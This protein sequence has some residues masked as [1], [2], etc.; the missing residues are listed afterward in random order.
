MYSSLRVGLLL[1]PV[2][3]DAGEVGDPGVAGHY[4][5]LLR[6]DA[7]P[8]SGAADATYLDLDLDVLDAE[9]AQP[10]N[11]V[12][13]RVHIVPGGCPLELLAGVLDLLCPSLLLVG[14]GPLLGP[15]AAGVGLGALRQ[16]CCAV[17]KSQ[18]DSPMLTYR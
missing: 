1:A 16:P 6:P 12:L 8:R 7:R 15:P 13:Y 2:E 17:Q 3:Q 10:V 4:A 11:P 18:L 9:D 5:P 14:D